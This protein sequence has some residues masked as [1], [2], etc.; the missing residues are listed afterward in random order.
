MPTLPDTSMFCSGEK[1]S[2]R[3]IV[4]YDKIYF[5]RINW[6]G[7]PGEWYVLNEKADLIKQA[8]ISS[9][10]TV[11]ASDKYVGGFGGDKLIS[12]FSEYPT[13]INTIKGYLPSVTYCNDK[14]GIATRSDNSIVVHGTTAGTYTVRGILLYK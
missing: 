6:D 11:T 8:T 14:T 9:T 3:L 2:F 7:I 5:Q 4:Y 13:D 12:A 10:I 1:C